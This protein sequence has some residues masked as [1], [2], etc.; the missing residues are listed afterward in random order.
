MLW[1]IEYAK[2]GSRN[3]KPYIGQFGIFAYKSKYNA[4]KEM[5]FIMRIDRIYQGGESKFRVH[6]Y[7]SDE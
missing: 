7:T 3:W 6:S 4:K 5:T 1:V 2:K